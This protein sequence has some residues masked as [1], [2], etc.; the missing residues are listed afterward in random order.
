MQFRK[1]KSRLTS[2]AENWPQLSHEL[3]RP[4]EEI[5]IMDIIGASNPVEQLNL[6]VTSLA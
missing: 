3:G 4:E 2:M 5:D 6:S 1:A